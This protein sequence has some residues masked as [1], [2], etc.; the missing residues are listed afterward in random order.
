[1]DRIDIKTT[2]I[3]ANKGKIYTDGTDYGIIMFLGANKNKDDFYE[4]TIEE[5]EKI[6]E[7]KRKEEESEL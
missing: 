2:K 7:E 1:M 6:L 5:Y 4:I 3:K